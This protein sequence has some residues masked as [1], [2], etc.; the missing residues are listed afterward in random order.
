MVPQLGQLVL[1][2]TGGGNVG[3]VVPRWSRP[4]GPSETA[5]YWLDLTEWLP[6]SDVVTLT[7]ITIV[8]ITGDP[9]P[10]TLSGAVLDLGSLIIP[11]APGLTFNSLGPRMR[12]LFSAGKAGN[13]YTVVFSWTDD[14]LRTIARSAILSV[15]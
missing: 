10:L 2:R 13:F 5:W 4:K 8:G 3:A 11:L 12:A 14:Q 6:V 9:T 1:L 15:E 7:S